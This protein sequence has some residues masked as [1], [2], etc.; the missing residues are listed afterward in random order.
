MRRPLLLVATL[1]LLAVATPVAEADHVF[2]HRTYVV[3]RVVDAD[4]NPAAAMPVTLQ[5]ANLTPGGR[6]FDSRTEVT[7][8]QGDFTVCRHT[9]ALP[10]NASVTVTAGNVSATVPVDPDLRHAV[11]HLRL[12]EPSQA[13]DIGGERLFE[14]TYRVQGR[15]FTLLHAPENAE[16]VP[17]NATP[18]SGAN[19]TIRLVGPGGTLAER[20]AQV[21]EMGAYEASL[22]LEGAVPEG[23]TVR[24]E[25]GGIAATAKASPLF[26]RSDV[27]V[28]RET[29]AQISLDEVPGSSPTPVPALL[30]LAGLGAAVALRLAHRGRAR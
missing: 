11:A 1:V 9:H 4:G 7:G 24:V 12:D 20:V 18:R 2:S 29:P 21:D 25:S 27:H 30:P 19:V 17:V 5:F 13:R 10:S 22:E 14:R 8:P 28:L 3:G 23:A 16:G 26:R 6:C 15:V